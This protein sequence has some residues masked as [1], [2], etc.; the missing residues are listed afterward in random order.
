MLSDHRTLEGWL[1]HDLRVEP[2]SISC[3]L[4]PSPGAVPA[5]ST[6]KINKK[7]IFKLPR[8]AAVPLRVYLKS[9][10]QLQYIITNQQEGGRKG[11]RER[12]GEVVR[13]NPDCFCEK[14]TVKRW[15]GVQ[16][17]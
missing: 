9:S 17:S 8:G 10:G 2:Q 6:D 3:S 11:R 4:L 1:N 5:A 7:V 13:S 14:L 15:Q 12:R 16:A